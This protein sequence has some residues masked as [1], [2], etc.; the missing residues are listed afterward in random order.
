MIV[1]MIKKIGILMVAVAL[2]SAPLRAADDFDKNLA[3]FKACITNLLCEK[4]KK[5]DGEIEKFIAH[6]NELINHTFESFNLSLREFFVSEQKT[7]DNSFKQFVDCRVGKIVE[8]IEGFIG[9]QID[10]LQSRFVQQLNLVNCQ[11]R[12]QICI[13]DVIDSNLDCFATNF[14]SYLEV[15]D[16]AGDEGTNPFFGQLTSVIVDVQECI[17]NALD[18]CSDAPGCSDMFSDAP[19]FTQCPQ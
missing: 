15:L 5:L 17:D 16:S 2:C 7:N 14:L 18:L 8:N 13:M 3:Q 10:C 9:H 4:F 19:C 11:I 12:S 6:E 1:S